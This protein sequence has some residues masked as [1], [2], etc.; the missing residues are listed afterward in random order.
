MANTNNLI[1]I[2][3]KVLSPTTVNP[4][5]TQAQPVRHVESSNPFNP[6]PFVTTTIDMNNY[7]KN[8]PV[9]GGYFAGY[10][11]GK[12]NIVGRRLFVEV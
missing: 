9:Q 4:Q 6:N 5:Q 8:R 12:P 3:N 10:Y 7:A 11:N 2:F 1:S